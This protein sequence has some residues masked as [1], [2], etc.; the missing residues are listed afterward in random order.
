M[1]RSTHQILTA[2]S[3]AALSMNANKLNA[4]VVDLWL[5]DLSCNSLQQL[6]HDIP[7]S[8]E[9][10][11][12]AA[13]FYFAEHRRHY[14]LAHQY[15]RWVLSQY[16]DLSPE[17]IMFTKNIYGKPELVEFQNTLQLQFNLSHSDCFIAVGVGKTHDLGVDIETI[18]TDKDIT[19]LAEHCFSMQ[20]WQHFSTLTT[21]QQQT[22]FYRH[23]SRKEAY[24]KA[25]GTGLHT[26]TT[27]FSIDLEPADNPTPVIDTN[28]Q[29]AKLKIWTIEP[30]G[31]KNCAC[32][33]ATQD[34]ITSI[35]LQPQYYADSF[36]SADTAAYLV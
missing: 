8:D 35:F 32:A 7:L 13:A 33:V 19:A 30:T 22:E 25:L 11:Q 15:L 36:F 27:S 28:S 24:V 5:D 9:E 20:E 17:N 6:L 18:K 3:C 12:R 4:N 16:V 21:A 1:R 34:T 31:L 23:W 26:P 29:E 10:Q 2:P 14:V